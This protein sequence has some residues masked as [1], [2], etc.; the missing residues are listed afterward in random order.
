MTNATVIPNFTNATLDFCF[1]GTGDCA[2]NNTGGTYAVR[3]MQEE[4]EDVE[5]AARLL[6]IEHYNKYTFGAESQ[7][8]KQRQLRGRRVDDDTLVSQYARRLPS[9]QL[10]Y[11]DTQYRNID[12]ESG[13]T[14]KHTRATCRVLGDLE[15]GMTYYIKASA[16]VVKDLYGLPS[17]SVNSKAI[18]KNQRQSGCTGRCWSA[19]GCVCY[20]ANRD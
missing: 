13:D 19:Q 12:Y 8:E 10:P 3:R 9:L 17:A 7:H 15:A 18:W 2:I 16:G 11:D 4:D 5:D 14:Y 20:C 6:P 1:N